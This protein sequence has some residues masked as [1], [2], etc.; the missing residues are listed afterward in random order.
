MV[1]IMERKRLKNVFKV[2]KLFLKRVRII[3][4]RSKL[5]KN[6]KNAYRQLQ[7]SN[8][9]KQQQENTTRYII[10]IRNTKGNHIQNS[11]PQDSNK[12]DNH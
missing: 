5:Y 8:K 4:K 6:K 7:E 10:Y 12:K 2:A 1:E 11:Q 9:K 3:L